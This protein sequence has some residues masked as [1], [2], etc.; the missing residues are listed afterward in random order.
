MPDGVSSPQ[1][2]LKNGFQITPK[3]MESREDSSNGLR[4]EDV[5]LTRIM[6]W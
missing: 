1:E 2:S 5:C 6:D 3:H 4:I